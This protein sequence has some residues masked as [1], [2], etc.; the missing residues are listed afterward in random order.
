MCVCVCVC[1]GGGGG[2]QPWAKILVLCSCFQVVCKRPSHFIWFSPLELFV[3]ININPE[4]PISF[5]CYNHYDTVRFSW[6][7]ICLI[8]IY[9]ILTHWSLDNMAYILWAANLNSCIFLHVKFCR[10]MA[11][12]LNF[13]LK[14]PFDDESTSVYKWLF[15]QM[16]AMPFSK[17][18]IT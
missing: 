7:I 2:R 16:H 6:V 8:F 3:S 18:M 12:S 17:R 1:G 4:L 15:H 14:C 13:V 11:M 10:L 5:L 9:I